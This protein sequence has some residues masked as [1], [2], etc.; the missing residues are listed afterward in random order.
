ME[1]SE[2]QRLAAQAY[3]DE[4]DTIPS[5]RAI[6]KERNRLRK[7]S[8]VKGWAGLNDQAREDFEWWGLRDNGLPDDAERAKRYLVD[9]ILKV[10]AGVDG[11]SALR[12]AG[13]ILLTWFVHHGR[14]LTATRL[15][16]ASPEN[17]RGDYIE[18]RDGLEY[19]PS[20]AVKFLAEQF[21]L[22]DPA[23]AVPPPGR[24]DIRRDIDAA[25]TVVQWFM[26]LNPADFA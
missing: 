15:R 12:A 11:H 8:T 3:R 7:V 6:T 5:R 21:V 14:P 16:A 24:P 17:S 1:L 13:T 9:D 2:A 18:R 23:L 10:G 26:G 4:L 19:A 22:L 25:Y 20:E